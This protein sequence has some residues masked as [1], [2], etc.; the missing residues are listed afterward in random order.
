[1]RRLLL[2]AVALDM[3]LF[4]G[5]VQAADSQTGQ[6]ASAR[7]YYNWN[8]FY[9]G[10]HV[11]YGRAYGDISVR[12]PVAMNSS[13]SLGSLFGGL[14]FGYNYVLPSRLMIG[15]E[16]DMSMPNS[17]P[18]DAQIWSGTTS[19]S[20]LRE[21]LDY[22][23]T[24]R[25]R[26]GYAFDK[27]LL[28]VTGG[29]TVSNSHF[30]RSDPNSG[31]EQLQ[32]GL[33]TG[34]VVG[35]GI[36]YAF[37]QNWNAR[38][39]YLYS[40]FGPAGTTFMNGVQ[41]ESRFDT[42]IIRVGLNRK[43]G[44]LES[45]AM[46][47]SAD[48]NSLSD[49]DQWEIHGQTT[50]IQQGY[51]RFH[52][53]YTGEN[54]L[55]PWPQSKETFSM[56]A[57]LGL[58]LWNGA[59]LYYNP[60]LLQGFGLSSTVGAAGFPNGEAQKS[61]FIYPRYTT[62][63]LFFRQYFG[64]GGEQEK[65]ESAYGRMAGKED[66]SRLTIQVGKFAVHD[67]FD[68]NS[69]AQD[70]RADFFNWSIWAA[71]AFDYAGNKIGATSGAVAE[72][73]QKTW[74]LRTGYFLIGDKPNSDNFDS[75]I[76]RRGGYVTEF[77]YRYALWSQPGKLRLIGWLNEAFSGSFR[78]A[79]NI[80]NSTGIDPTTAIEQTRTGRAEYGYVINLE[81]QA[82]DNV[83]LFGRWS[84]NN[85]K[86]EMSAFTDINSS[87]SGGVVIK[88][89]YWGRPDDRIGIAGAIN[90][91]SNDYQKYLVAGGLG[92]LIGDGQLN[93]RR[94]KLLETFYALYL[95]KS[96]TLTFDYQ[97]MVNPAYNA[98]RGPISFFAGRVHAEF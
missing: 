75:Q 80:S 68:N 48:V 11:G 9:L 10:G 61:D 73:N 16:T 49:S 7:P 40:S 42:P 63:K 19:H 52:A 25:G 51:P 28:Y 70:S 83:G 82:S 97:F 4:G 59:E 18:S 34:W 33:R 66:I 44:G 98:D 92:I 17:Y 64:L 24:L 32:P 38:F 81:Q 23:A 29:F 43:L 2:Q 50:Y 65:I 45:S 3:L 12:D 77:E 54:S 57:F 15:I 58:R 47:S 53:P 26:F 13:P 87:L 20:V 8:G 60:E 86:S 31:D 67:I 46:K 74:A 55:P 95:S 84:W 1:M 93:Y 37:Q 27:T 21:Q 91:I 69:Y 36:E 39:E 78:D 6:T 96:V 14:Q 30:G 56:S 89:K 79:V 41:Y 71:G 94:E 90:G 72:L 5:L 62:S 22:I 35:G 85:G 76:F 88:G